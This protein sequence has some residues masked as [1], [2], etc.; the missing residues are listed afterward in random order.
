MSTLMTCSVCGAAM[1][2]DT[3]L[4]PKCGGKTNSPK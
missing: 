2:V 3:P 1:P 4:C